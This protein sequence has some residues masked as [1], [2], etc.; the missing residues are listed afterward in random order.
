MLVKECM[1]KNVKLGRP[2]MTVC[3]AA[4]KMKDGHFG[5]L[6]IEENDRLVGM[7]TDRDI[8]IRGVAEGKDSQKIKVSEIM[9][10]KV[11]YC[12]EDQE[13][14]EI[15][16]NFAK[17]QVRRLPVLSRKKRLVGILSL[18]DMAKS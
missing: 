15:A 11:L 8:A 16:Q 13:L 4:Q 5:I 2:D 12:Y 1:T 18:A 3:E 7:V 6:P 17:N 9:S 14:D 10:K